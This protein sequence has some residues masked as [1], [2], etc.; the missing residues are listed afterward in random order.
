MSK[1]IKITAENAAAIE[2]ALAEG[3]GRARA[4]TFT[5]AA[6][7]IHEAEAAESQVADLDL[8]QSKRAGARYI[9]YSC[10]STLPTSYR[11][12]AIGTRVTLRRRTGGWYLESVGRYD[13]YSGHGSAPKD[14][15]YLT[16]EQADE[17]TRRFQ[18]R[19]SVARPVAVAA[20]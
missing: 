8:P 17:V 16:Q 10:T 20:A 18:A 13:I 1:L 15:L 4:H 5:C 3:N 11:Y 12:S 19:F 2:A 7:I 6:E 9:A 14:R